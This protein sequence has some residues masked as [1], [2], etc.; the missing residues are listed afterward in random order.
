V[1][2]PTDEAF[3]KFE[4]ATIEKLKT[5]APLLTSILTYQVVPGQAS[6][7]QVAGDQKTVQGCQRH[8]H[9]CW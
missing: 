7:T 8:G 1:F 3:G 6:P 4:S 5:D 9:R 2:A